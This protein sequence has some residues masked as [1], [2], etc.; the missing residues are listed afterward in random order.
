MDVRKNDLTIY[1][2]DQLAIVGS[3]P[4]GAGPTHLVADKHGRLIAT[5]TRGDAVRVFSTEPKEVAS[6]PQPGAPYGITYDATRD[7]LWVASSATNEVVGYDMAQDTP[8][9][10][11]RIPTVQKPVHR[12]GRHHDRAALRR[13]CHRRCGADHRASR[14][15]LG[16]G[17]WRFDCGGDAA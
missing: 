17:P 12:R 1:D 5:D 10:V 4:A 2:T 14:R 16:W 13:G 9:E 7:R 11:Q 3:T 15:G 6:V 8:Q